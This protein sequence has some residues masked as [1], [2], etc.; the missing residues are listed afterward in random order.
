MCI[1]HLGINGRVS[2]ATC[3]NQTYF[4]WQFIKNDDG[5]YLIESKNGTVLDVNEGSI[6]N[7][8]V[9]LANYKNGD[10]SQKWT[11]NWNV[12]LKYFLI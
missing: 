12:Q 5:T 11:V 6:G 1:K 9:I 8:A 10:L 2:Q 3:K 4:L 7:E